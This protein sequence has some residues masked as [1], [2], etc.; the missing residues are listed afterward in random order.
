MASLTPQPQIKG[1]ANETHFRSPITQCLIFRQN[2]VLHTALSFSKS[3]RDPS[4]TLFEPVVFARL[5]FRGPFYQALQSHLKGRTKALE[6]GD[7]D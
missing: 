7:V 3:P 4:L 2:F 5:A 6:M 1:Q